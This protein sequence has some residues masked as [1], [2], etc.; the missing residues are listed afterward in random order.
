MLTYGFI[1]HAQDL[2]YTYS[3]IAFPGATSTSPRGI[4]SDGDVAGYYETSGQVYGFLLSAGNYTT[5]SCP[6]A[7]TGT[8]VYGINDNGV[9]VG[10]YGTAYKNYGFIYVN[11]ECKNLQEF[12]GETPHPTGINDKGQIVGYYIPATDVT[13]GFELVEGTYT[14]IS[15]PNSTST[16]AVGINRSGVISGTYYNSAGQYGFTFSN[17]SYTT[18]SFPASG[19]TTNGAGLNDKSLIV[20][21]YDDPTTQAYEGFV[22][23]TTK[24]QTLIVPASV[25]TFPSAINDSGVVVGSYFNGTVNPQGFL[26]TPSN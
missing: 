4:N 16:T 23:N 8:F 20:G 3:D 9:I 6:A 15:V 13:E 14:E 11:G 22:T 19:A 1:A 5:I 18:L 24:F 26:A 21:S 17:G 12:N 2:T 25:T 10:Y 7:T